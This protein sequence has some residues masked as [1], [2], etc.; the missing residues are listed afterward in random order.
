MSVV[1]ARGVASLRPVGAV[2]IAF[3]LRAAACRDY[4][5]QYPGGGA[6]EKSAGDGGARDHGGAGARGG[7]QDMVGGTAN[8][9][10]NPQPD[11][12]DGGFASAGGAE[13]GGASA[14]GE[15][16]SAG[17]GGEGDTPTVGLE[18][19]A[20]D[21]LALWLEASDSSC[22]LG[23]DNRVSWCR[24]L[25]GKGNHAFQSDPLLKPKYG[26]A[27]VNGRPALTFDGEPSVMIVADH[28]SLQFGSDE[29]MYLVVARWRNE[30]EPSAAYGGYGSLLAKVEAASPYR[31]VAL[32][33]NY[34]AVFPDL[35][36]LRRF[37]VQ[38]EASGGLVLSYSNYL[39]D[40][41]F[42]VYAARRVG[43]RL[44]MRINGEVQA[45][46]Q[47]AIELDVSAKGQALWIGGPKGQ[48]LRGDIAEIIALKGAIGEVGLDRLESHLLR[49]FGL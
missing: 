41:A 11:G 8:E 27:L 47:I 44:E 20:F 12:G 29:F 24:D 37:A 26:A 28:A 25:S 9:P 42:R 32:L 14:G 4:D 36:A 43:E 45:A 16:A 35:P 17:A 10:P 2:L 31:G 40:D 48:Q 6:G 1:R 34:P 30:A 22:S 5:P 33:A 46:T 39:N 21:N 49:K 38:L 15:D 23:A 3:F 19:G 18:P 13:A 7:A